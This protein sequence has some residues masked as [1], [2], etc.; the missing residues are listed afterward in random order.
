MRD[1]GLA[2]AGPGP[3]NKSEGLGKAG[4]AQGL[5]TKVKGWVAG[6]AQELAGAKP[7]RG[8]QPCFVPH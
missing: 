4:L 6:P 8:F 3:V 1:A 7:F 5:S 2:M